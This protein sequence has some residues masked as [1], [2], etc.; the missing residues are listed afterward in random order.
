MGYKFISIDTNKLIVN[1]ENPRF[2]SVKNEYEAIETIILNQQEKLLNLIEDIA[3]NGLNPSE[4]V[5]VVEEEEEEKYVVLEGNRRVTAIKLINDLDFYADIDSKFAN[6]VSVILS[7]K[8]AHSINK[9]NTI[10]FE[11]RLEANRWIKIK[12]TGENSGVGI[13]GWSKERKESFI[14][15]NSKMDKV[16]K[17]LQY[18]KESKYYSDDLKIRLSDIKLSNL[19]RLLDDPHVRETI[20]LTLK[21][22]KFYR[23]VAEEELSKGLSKI[24]YDILNGIF[25]GK[26]ISTKENRLAYIEGFTEK[27][28]PC[29]EK[30]VIEIATLVATDLND[31]NEI[32]YNNEQISLNDFNVIDELTMEVLEEDNKSVLPKIKIKNKDI[33]L[34]TTKNNR[35]RRK[36]LIPSDFNVKIED[37]AL[38]AIYK[39][40]KTL[41]I[42]R[43]S[44]SVEILFRVFLEKIVLNYIKKNNLDIEKNENLNL[45]ETMECIII[46]L[47]NKGKIILEDE[48]FVEEL[49]KEK[50][51]IFN[52]ETLKD[53]TMNKERFIDI[54]SLKRSWDIL[55]ELLKILILN[56][57]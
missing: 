1:K 53:Y 43:Y 12:H 34:A 7:K 5:I 46:D 55:E 9:I 14:S 20:G 18:V 24:L 45:V 32:L 10:V 26:S 23:L 29:Y 51:G 17:V 15:E 36:Y 28:L 11:E 16:Y 22:K 56:I 8:S 27:Q 4:L 48:A 3:G 49:L 2:S 44:N 39:E 37:K 30:E 47:K 52:S 33:V 19:S 35:N 50:K 21:N 31:S 54:I 40:L 42:K 41:D 25:K 38:G 57:N 13:L 6:K